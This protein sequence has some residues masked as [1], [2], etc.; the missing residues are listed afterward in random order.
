MNKDYKACYLVPLCL[1]PRPYHCVGAHSRYLIK[2][3]I[4]IALIFFPKLLI[5]K[6]IKPNNYRTGMIKIIID[7]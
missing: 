2:Y 6:I 7:N 3:Y 4:G 1:L 5:L